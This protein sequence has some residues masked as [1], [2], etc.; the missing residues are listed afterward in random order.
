ME[1]KQLRY[2]KRVAD[3]GSV[4]KA[5]AALSVAQPAVSRQIAALE[6]SLGT[7]LFFRNGRGVTLT[8]AGQE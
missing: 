4:S 3:T 1:L 5:A 7:P 2:F 6:D 8:E